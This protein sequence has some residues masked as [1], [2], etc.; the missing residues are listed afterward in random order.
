MKKIFFVF[1]GIA[2]A[3][4]SCNKEADQNVQT[5]ENLASY[6]VVIGTSTKAVIAAGDDASHMDIKWADGD[7]IAFK[8]S[9]DSV[10]GATVTM[11]GTTAKVSVKVGANTITD[12]WFPYSAEKP[13]GV[14]DYQGANS[15]DVPLAMTGISG[16]TITFDEVTSDWAIVRV[17]VKAGINGEARTLVFVKFK[18]NNPAAP[19]QVI[20]KNCAT[21]LS[22]D[23]KYFDFVVPSGVES[24]TE[25]IFRD[26]NGLEYRRKGS[27]YTFESHNIYELPTI[28]DID[29]T[30]RH[31]W[32]F[33]GEE[34]PVDNPLSN[35]APF[36]YWFRTQADRFATMTRGADYWT[37][38]AWVQN[39][40]QFKYR[41]GF[42]P[43]LNDGGQG[44]SS[45]TWGTISES[46]T[47]INGVE[48]QVM[49]FTVHVGN[50]PIFA[51]KITKLGTLGNSR[52][53]KLD[54]NSILAENQTGNAFYGRSM[55]VKYFD[56]VTA[57][58]TLSE[59]DTEGIYYF[60][61]YNDNLTFKFGDG[62][63]REKLP[64]SRALHFTTWQ[65]QIPDVTYSEIQSP[66]PTCNIYWAVDGKVDF[67]QSGFEK[68]ASGRPFQR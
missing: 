9:D 3:L 5:Q 2:L 12:A 22:D 25:I 13:S 24:T 21:L 61:F 10:V 52:N 19:V 51:V 68:G 8:L 29:D 53:F 1:A 17:P 11:D 63:S 30:G 6:S 57:K 46:K 38:E 42:A 58:R 64:S 45:S 65:V 31:I 56:A 67:R 33:K 15:V 7:K 28:A 18:N 50:Y 4:V 16:D 66:L 35:N 34:G 41:F 48:N 36:T 26:T 20:Q 55:P 27:A 54:V 60:D 59:T 14:P 40:A 37:Q 39:E 44:K 43:S 32:V 49:R 23:V 62:S 47:T